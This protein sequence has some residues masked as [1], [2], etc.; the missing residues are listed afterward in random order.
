VY[1]NVRA[2]S[3]LTIHCF[4]SMLERELDRRQANKD[5]PAGLPDTIFVQFD[6]APDNANRF[7]IA[8]C[9]LVVAC[10]LCKKIVTSRLMV[11]HTHCDI[12]GLFG[13]IWKKLWKQYILTP[14]RYKAAIEGALSKIGVPAVV[15]D[16]F[17]V[18]DYMSWIGPYIDSKF[19]LAFKETHTQLQFTFEAT[20]DIQNFP[21]G[22]KVGG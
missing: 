6:G 4:L 17:V 13:I 3:N 7:L 22:V 19:G 5:G 21:N 16:I 9:E 12:D 18:P 10:G 20:T 8:I 14:Q 1:N 11:G 15:E 2:N